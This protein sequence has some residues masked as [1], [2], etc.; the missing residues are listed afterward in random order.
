M[1]AVGLGVVGLDDDLDLEDDDGFGSAD[2]DDL[3]DEG[4]GAHRAGDEDESDDDADWVM[5]M[6][7]RVEGMPHC[8]WVLID[9]GDV[10]VH[11]FRPEVRQFYN[12]EKIWSVESPHRMG[13]ESARV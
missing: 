9:A 1:P 3:L 4:A 10:I 5:R 6:M 12:L 11:L 13:G 7:A 8:D 2:D